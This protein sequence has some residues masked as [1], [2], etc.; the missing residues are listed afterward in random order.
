[1]TS[2]FAAALGISTAITLSAILLLAARH[3]L[4]TPPELIGVR[5]ALLQSVNSVATVKEPTALASGN[6]T[7]RYAWTDDG[8]LPAP[9]KAIE[10]PFSDIRPE[11]TGLV[12]FVYAISLNDLNFAPLT[13]GPG[14]ATTTYENSQGLLFVQIVNGGDFYLNGHWVAGLAQSTLEERWMW[15]RPFIVPLPSHLL[16][17]DG[18]PNIL[19]ASQSS[20]EP[21]ISIPRPYFGTLKELSRIAGIASFFGN[22]LANSFGMLC[23]VAGFFLLSAWTVSPKSPIYAWGGSAG[24]LWAVLFILLSWHNISTDMRG[25]W[26][27]AV[28]ICESGLVTLMTLSIYAFMGKPI[29]KFWGVVLVLLAGMAPVVYAVGGFATEKALDL[30]WTPAIVMMYVYAIAHLVGFCWRKRS[31]AAVMLLG[32][33]VIFLGLALHDYAVQSGLINHISNAGLDAGWTALLQEPIFLAPLSMPLLLVFISYILLRQHQRNIG[34][35]AAS[36]A[37]LTDTLH[38]REKELGEVHEKMKAIARS[39]AVLSERERIYQDIHDGVGSQLVKAIFSLRTRGEGYAEV[40]NNL[41]A[42]L[43]DLRFIIES[44]TESTMDVQSAVFAF[45]LTQESHLEGSGLAIHY[46]VGNENTTY[47]DTRI[48]L[49]VLRVLQESLSNTIKHS[50]ASLITVNIQLVACDLILSITDNG[51]LGFKRQHQKQPSPYGAPGGKGIPGLAMRAAEIGGTYKIDIG[52]S[53]TR[54]CLSIPLPQATA[55]TTPLYG[56]TAPHQVG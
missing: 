7:E 37:H 54:V 13:S 4:L 25:V 22:T 5:N 51:H 35:L 21:N 38:H 47:A 3:T 28:Y 34:A 50:N 27:L 49:N 24:I 9:G 52:R 14:K 42:C 30:V 2:R 31:K 19:V 18:R 15:F 12:N 39:E 11:G 43:Q 20:L 32:Q 6:N 10:L 41:Q 53:G 40:E 56:A 44:H 33:S 36:G 46:S 48:N 29:G 55:P 23:L 45:C 17:R 16:Y 26:R 1:M 8:R